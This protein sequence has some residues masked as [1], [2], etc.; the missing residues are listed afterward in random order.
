MKKSTA[1]KLSSLALG[2]LASAAATMPATAQDQYIGQMMQVPYNFCPMGWLMAD[3]ALVSIAQYD[4]LFALYGT[5][6]GGDGV[7]TF[8]LPDMRGR[9]PIGIGQGT[10][11]I[12]NYILGERGGVETQTLTTNTMPAHSHSVQATSSFGD[13]PGPGGKFLAADNTGVNKYHDG[14]PNKTMSPSMLTPSGGSMPFDILS[15]YLAMR[16]CVAMEGIFPS[17]P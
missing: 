13:L 11:G 5:T 2:L 7:N 12:S 1:F 17:Q 15:P 8:A 3:G 9:V 10:G 14:P 4:T 16:W 6:F